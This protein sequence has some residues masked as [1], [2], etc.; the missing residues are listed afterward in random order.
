MISQANAIMKRK[1]ENF[2]SNQKGKA[3]Y[4]YCRLAVWV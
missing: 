2:L 4:L 1:P 3:G